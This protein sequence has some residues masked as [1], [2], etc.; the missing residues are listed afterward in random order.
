MHII[1]LNEVEKAAG[2][3]ITMALRL[4]LFPFPLS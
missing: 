4:A 3:N 2:S 1:D